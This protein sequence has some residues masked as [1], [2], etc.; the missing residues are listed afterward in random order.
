MSNL[1][2]EFMKKE[3]RMVAK[4]NKHKR[5]NRA[6]KTARLGAGGGLLAVI[7]LFPAACDNTGDDDVRPVAARFSAGINGLES[8]ATE[9]WWDKGDRIGVTGTCGSVEYKNVAHVVTNAAAGSF[10]VDNATGTDNT[11]YFNDDTPVTFTAYYPH[12]GNNGA[13][14]PVQ[15]TR[16]TAKAQSA[17]TQSAIDYLHATATGSKSAPDVEFAFTHRMSRVVLSIKRGDGVASLASLTG[18]TLAGFRL[19][20]SFDPATGT[21]EANA[22]KSAESLA[23][24]LAATADSD[25]KVTSSL[26]LY[27]Q[28]VATATFSVTLT[29]PD[30]QTFTADLSIPDG[31]LEAGKS[32]AYNVTVSKTGITISKATIGTWTDTQG[33]DATAK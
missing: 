28:S 10:A 19:D 1:N 27:P 18:Y 15:T 24:P 12:A 6:I 30:A 13:D 14:A 25:A 9:T 22:S 17:A 11:I 26:I 23:M 31:K 8:R 16:T 7:T 3:R 21:A 32:Y 5:T 33:G 29:V 20:G 4:N 2:I